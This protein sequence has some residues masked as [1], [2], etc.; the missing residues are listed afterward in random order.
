MADEKLNKVKAKKPE[1]KERAKAKPE[2][3][4]ARP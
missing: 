4:A 3:P 1:V 2:K